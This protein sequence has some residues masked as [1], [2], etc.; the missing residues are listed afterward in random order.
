MIAE[1]LDAVHSAPGELARFTPDLAAGTYE[2][3]L[4]EATPFGEDSTF[5][6]RVRHREGETTVRVRP[7][8]SRRIGVFEFDEGT[9]GFVEIP[10]DG[11]SGLVIADAVVFRPVARIRTS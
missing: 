2:V 9:D 1:P 7:G 10:A 4:S 5:D 3:V 6:V 8:K 11:S